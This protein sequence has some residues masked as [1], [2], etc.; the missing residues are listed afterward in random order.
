MCDNDCAQCACKK[1]EEWPEG[2]VDVIGQN[3]NDG[4]HYE[5]EKDDAAEEAAAVQD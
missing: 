5:Q 1:T 4:L 3:G 2:R